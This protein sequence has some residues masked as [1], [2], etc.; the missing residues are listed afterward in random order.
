MHNN[1][2]LVLTVSMAAGLFLVLIGVAISTAPK[3]GDKG[4]S[5]V[6][7][8]GC[9]LLA[10][11][12]AATAAYIVLTH[13]PTGAYIDLVNTYGPPFT[14]GLY[15]AM[16]IIVISPLVTTLALWYVRRTRGYR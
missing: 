2:Y 4:L 15:L 9:V 16:I 13:V 12:V 5:E 6:V 7:R 1:W 11:G 10:Q 3:V 8:G 14:Y